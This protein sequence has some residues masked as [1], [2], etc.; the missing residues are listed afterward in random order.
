MK[1]GLTQVYTGA[2]KGKTT[3]AL[4]LAL[5]AVGQGLRVCIIQFMKPNDFKTG[6]KAASQKLAPNLEIVQFGDSQVWGKGK[7]KTTLTASMKEACNEALDFAKSKVQDSHYD[8]IVLD[9]V[10]VALSLG[11]LS[12]A[13]I[14]ELI[15]TKPE[16]V[17][18]VLT[19]RSAPPEIIELADLITEMR[20]VKHP[21][22]KGIKA[23]QGIDY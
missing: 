17:E 22:Q 11:L 13:E 2:G 19:G 12:L 20:E 6:E 7:P 18:L 3:A 15:K 14:I 23:R 16:A 1:K 21:Y 9:E 5:R 8:I 10:L 4:G